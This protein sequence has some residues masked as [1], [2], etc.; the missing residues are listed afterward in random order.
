MKF[1]DTHHDA[2]RTAGGEDGP[3]PHPAAKEG[4]LLTLEQACHLQVGPV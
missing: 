1:I 4:L 2:W 3:I